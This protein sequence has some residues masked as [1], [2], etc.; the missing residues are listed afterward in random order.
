MKGGRSTDPTGILAAVGFFFVQ[1][2]VF[3]EVF[4]H[5]DSGWTALLV[6]LDWAGSERVRGAKHLGVLELNTLI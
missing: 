4:G 6:G 2:G 1:R 5:K 3:N